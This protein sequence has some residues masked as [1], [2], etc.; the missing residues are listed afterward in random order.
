MTLAASNWNTADSFLGQSYRQQPYFRQALQGQASYFYGVG[1][2]TGTPGFF[3]AE[4][5][6]KGAKVVGVM[7]VKVSFDVLTRSWATSPDPLLLL[8]SQGIVFL[9][10]EPDWLYQSRSALTQADLAWLSQDGQ[11]GAR[12]SYPRLPWQVRPLT[13]ATNYALRTQVKSQPRALLA[14]ETV[15]PALGWTL[16]V[17]GDLASVAQARVEALVLTTLLA[18]VLLLA[19]LYWR[20]RE[21]RYAEQRQAKQDLEHRVKER[22]HDLERAQAFRKAMEDALLA[23]MRARPAGPHHLRQPRVLRHGGLPCR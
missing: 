10:S 3:I 7:V 6:R 15:M 2:T 20:L 21:R 11:Y 4:P 23:G 16:V 22:T 5:V 8:D 17:T 19:G 18:A 9:S 1:P 12:A 13:D 14:L